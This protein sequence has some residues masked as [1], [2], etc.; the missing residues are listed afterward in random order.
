MVG[1]SPPA[2]NL[3][4]IRQYNMPL[5]L[6][7]FAVIV[8]FVGT[9]RIEHGYFVDERGFIFGRDFVNFW[10]YGQG[11]WTGAGAN[12]YDPL[13][14]NAGLDALIPG[15]NYPAQL[16]SY[17]PHYMLVAAP[18]GLF[19][20][21]MVL[22][23]FTFLGFTLDWFTIVRPFPDAPFRIALF[24]V[25]TVALLFMCGQVSAFLAVLLVCI[26]RTLDTRPVLGRPSC[27]LGRGSW[28]AGVAR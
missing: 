6:L 3:A 4:L 16:F 15:H 27:R 20:Y 10:H 7:N 12:Y 25:P 19:G 8:F 24:V 18:F 28:L 26:N 17:P 14:Y 22:A 5:L 21:H 1:Q 2:P 13:V 9:L 23:V 11:A